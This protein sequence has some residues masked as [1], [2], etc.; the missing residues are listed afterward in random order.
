M[1]HEHKGVPPLDLTIA[2]RAARRSH[3]D[4]VWSLGHLRVCWAALLIAGLL[5]AVVA[6]LVSGAGAACGVAIGTLIVGLFFSVSAV[7]IAKA[8]QRNPRLVMPA[9]LGIYVVKIVALGVVLTVMPRDG[10]VDTHWMA[11]GVGLGL[12]CWLG[13]HMRYVWTSKIFYVDPGPS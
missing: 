6:A 7:V 13:A 5:L 11:G 4:G 1:T 3:T 10:F 2:D 12:F 9:A 8:G